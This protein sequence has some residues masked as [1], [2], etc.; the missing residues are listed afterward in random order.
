MIFDDEEIVNIIRSIIEFNDGDWDLMQ[1]TI[2]VLLK[3]LHI[4]KNNLPN[5]FFKHY[6]INIEEGG[7]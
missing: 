6:K 5:K 4:R 1:E 3:K 7:E 2:E